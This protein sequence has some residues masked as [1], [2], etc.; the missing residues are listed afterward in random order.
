MIK[1]ETSSNLSARSLRLCLALACCLVAALGMPIAAAEASE[2]EQV[3]TY[4]ELARLDLTTIDVILADT[5]LDLLEQEVVDDEELTELQIEHY[6][7]LL[8]GY[9]S[10]LA[11]GLSEL[12]GR[13]VPD[14]S[15]LRLHRDAQQALF[16]AADSLL[17]EYEQILGYTAALLQMSLSLENMAYYDENNLDATYQTISGAIQEALECLSAADVPTFLTYVNINLADSLTQ[18]DEAVLY[19]L[20][21]AYIDDPVRIY[22]ASYRMDILMRHFDS[23][24]VGIDQNIVDRQNKLVAEAEQIAQIAGGLSSWLDQNISLLASD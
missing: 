4:L 2:R 21:A 17:A 12:D 16:Q 9:R 5:E 15:D 10:S 14:F 24:V 11:G 13:Q 7:Q 3:R 19:T 1:S 20:Q 18:L 6:R 8:A 22:A 23:L